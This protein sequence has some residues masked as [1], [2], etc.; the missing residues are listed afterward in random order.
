[1]SPTVVLIA[2]SDLFFLSKIKTA[3]EA[4]GCG[5]HVATKIPAILQKA[6]SQNPSLLILDMGLSTLDPV[7]LLDEIRK[8]PTLERLPVLGYTNHTKLSKWQKNS[9]DKFLKV[10][11]NSHISGN[12][13]NVVGL[14]DLFNGL[15]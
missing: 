8:T 12:I 2:I 11:P 15:K 13:S 3:L 7:E 4:Q 10:V 5:V 14:L 1:M 6:L 9:S